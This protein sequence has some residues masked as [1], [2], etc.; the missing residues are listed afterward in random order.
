MNFYEITCDQLVV[1]NYFV[2]KFHVGTQLGSYWKLRFCNASCT[3]FLIG[4]I[5]FRHSKGYSRQKV[6]KLTEAMKRTG[7][8]CETVTDDGKGMIEQL[9][10]KFQRMS[11]RHEQLQI[12]TVLPK[13]WSIK[14]IQDQFPVTNYMARQTKIFPPLVQNVVHHCLLKQLN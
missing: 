1:L 9:K 4:T 5:P 2:V 3:F 11:Y 6:D 8:A 10:A 12:L 14:K 7:I 13:S